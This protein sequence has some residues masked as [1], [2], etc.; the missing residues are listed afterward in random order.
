MMRARRAHVHRGLRQENQPQH[1]RVLDA[2]RGDG[3]TTRRTWDAT[4]RV[5]PGASRRF[6]VFVA[7]GGN[8]PTTSSVASW[9]REFKKPVVRT[10]QASIWAMLRAFNSADRLPAF[11]RLL[12]EVPADAS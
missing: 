8:F 4:C 6:E 12:A 2:G 3:H 11:G 5:A 10:N 1:P 7:P 9:E